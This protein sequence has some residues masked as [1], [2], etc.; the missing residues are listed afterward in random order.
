MRIITI[1]IGIYLGP[2]RYE[3]HN[4]RYRYI[5]H[6]HMDFEIT[7]GP[8]RYED[9][10][11][12]YRYIPHSHMD[13]EITKGP[14]MRIITIGIGIYLTVIWTLKSPKVLI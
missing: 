5:P 4:Y 14:D 13:F 12:R 2:D 3:D 6:S 10:N 11:Y 8:D 1:G 7:K 9:H